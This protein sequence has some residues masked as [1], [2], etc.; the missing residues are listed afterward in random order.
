M[1]EIEFWD[2]FFRKKKKPN[3]HFYKFDKQKKYFER[4]KI[5]TAYFCK[6]GWWY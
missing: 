1:L 5:N 3:K 2:I 4:V 6:T